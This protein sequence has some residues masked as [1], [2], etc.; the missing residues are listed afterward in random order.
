MFTNCTTDVR[1]MEGRM[2]E[3]DGP[4]M[5]FFSDKNGSLY[6]YTVYAVG[7]FTPKECMDAYYN[8]YKQQEEIGG[9]IIWRYRP[10]LSMVEINPNGTVEKWKIYWRCYVM[11]PMDI[12][13]AVPFQKAEGVPVQYI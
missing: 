5:A 4:Q 1:T 7:C 2:I 8:W 3:I 11:P 13:D 10:E 12:T 9:Y 6:P